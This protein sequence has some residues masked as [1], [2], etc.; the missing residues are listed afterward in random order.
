M[1]YA[2]RVVQDA[3]RPHVEVV[4]PGE[5]RRARR[6]E[7]RRAPQAVDLGDA[8]RLPARQPA[9][10]RDERFADRDAHLA[11]ARDRDRRADVRTVRQPVVRLLL[12]VGQCLGVELV[13]PRLRDVAVRPVGERREG[14][15]KVR[16]RALDRLRVAALAQVERR[17]AALA[18]DPILELRRVR[19]QVEEEVEPV[20]G[21][22]RRDLL[23]RQVH[24]GRRRE[25][26]RAP[27]PV[28]VQPREV[29]AVVPERDA[30]RVHHRQDVHD[31][32][33]AHRARGPRVAKQPAQE[34]LTGPRAAALGRVLARLHPHADLARQR[35]LGDLQH[36]ERAALQR[37]ADR[38]PRRKGA[39]LEL[40]DEVRGARRGVRERV[41]EPHRRVVRERVR[42]CQAPRGPRRV[43]GEHP[44]PSGR[45]ARVA[46]H[47]RR[48]PARPRAGDVEGRQL[49]RQG[50][51]GRAPHGEVEPLPLRR[52]GVG[53]QLQPVAIRREQRHRLQVPRFER[54]VEGLRTGVA[55][56]RCEGQAEEQGSELGHGESSWVVGRARGPAPQMRLP[57]PESPANRVASASTRSGAKGPSP[58]RTR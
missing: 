34:A 32:V 7:L 24:L 39:G 45:V 55:G 14:V 10:E 21:L 29:R 35:A 43:G 58:I 44:R 4:R 9:V 19:V 26:R 50:A 30:V 28:Q 33:L 20:R 47:A 6:H 42:E 41:G 57:S 49:E 1:A 51:P 15:R 27:L 36:L 13:D 40:G 22:E 48:H 52:V 23:Q 37:G 8:V 31:R 25:A 38:P 16:E 46:R 17:A 5:R 53:P 11:V 3:G 56:E 18:E 2:E 12:G 54:A